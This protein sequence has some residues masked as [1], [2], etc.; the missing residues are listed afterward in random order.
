MKRFLDASIL[1]DA[2]LLQSPGFRAA[3]DLVNKTGTYTSAH[4]LAEAYATLSGDPH[5]K[6]NPRDAAQMVTEIAQTLT[7][8]ALSAADY[9]QL[10]AS[11]PVNGIRGGAIY[12]AIHAQTAR[13]CKCAELYTLN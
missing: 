5:L 9:H 6:I 7:V 4:A 10:I 3:D 1:I 2:C 13:F 11:A 8:H 12:D